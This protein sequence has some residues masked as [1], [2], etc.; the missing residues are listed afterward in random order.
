MFKVLPS[1]MIA[2]R[3]VRHHTRSSRQTCPR[4]RE[5]L[6]FK[7]KKKCSFEVTLGGKGGKPYKANPSVGS[8]VT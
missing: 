8:R 7:K 1:N 4:T 3:H 2:V 5:N 6:S